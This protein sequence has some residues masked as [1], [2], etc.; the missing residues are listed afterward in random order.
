M[1]NNASVA[2][3]LAEPIRIGD[4][5][6]AYVYADQTTWSDTY[7]Y[8]DKA[9]VTVKAGESFTLTLSYAGFDENWAPVSKPVAGATI[10]INGESIDTKTNDAGQIT[11]SMGEKS[12]KDAFVISA[13]SDAI[14]MVP[15]VCLVTVE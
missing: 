2:T 13:T 6:Y 10:T 7:C 1:L 4:H 15:P 8:F 12:K 5:V 9:E 3:S 11:I 14:V